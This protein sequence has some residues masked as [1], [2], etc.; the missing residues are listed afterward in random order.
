MNV[1]FFELKAQLRSFITWTIALVALCAAFIGAVLPLYMNEKVS[2]QRMLDSFPASFTKIFGIDTQNI[3][4]FEGFYSFIFLYLGMAAAIMAASFTISI[5]YREKRTKSLDFLLVKP[6]TR[7]SLFF[8]KLA[9]SLTLIVGANIFYMLTYTLMT[10][11]RLPD[12]SRNMAFYWAG[13]SVFFTQVLFMALG[14]AYAVSAKRI[15][16][17]AGTATSFGLIGFVLVSVSNLVDVA[18]SELISP[19]SYF[20]P[21]HVFEKGFYD[22]LMFMVA[23]AL[24]SASLAWAYTLFVRSDVRAE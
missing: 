9:A 6:R 10:A 18:Y 1:Y 8:S 17:V 14:A 20:S 15:R 23:L 7:S 24:A 5:F 21:A 11:A 2:F 16:S 4:G 22:P 13:L 12:Q 19:L 3:F